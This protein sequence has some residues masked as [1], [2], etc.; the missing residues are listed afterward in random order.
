MKK[1]ITPRGFLPV[2]AALLLS[3]AV[4]FCFSSCEP[5][6]YG[7]IQQEP[8]SQALPRSERLPLV[9]DFVDDAAADYGI[10]VYMP[11]CTRTEY[12]C[13][14][15]ITDNGDGTFALD[16]GKIKFGAM[17]DSLL[18]RVVFERLRIVEHPDQEGLYSLEAEEPG[19][20]E[21]LMTADKIPSSGKRHP[22]YQRACVRSKSAGLNTERSFL[23]IRK[24]R[25]LMKI[26]LDW[27]L[28]LSM[29]TEPGFEDYYA[30]QVPCPDSLDYVVAGVS[31][32]V[33]Y[34]EAEKTE[35]NDGCRDLI[36][37]MPS[38][39][40]I[41]SYLVTKGSFETVPDPA[42]QDYAVVMKPGAPF[43]PGQEERAPQDDRKMAVVLTEEYTVEG[44]KT[45]FIYMGHGAAPNYWNAGVFF[46]GTE[47]TLQP[48][49]IACYETTYR[50]WYEVY[51][52]AVNNGYS[53]YSPGQ[54][55]SFGE[56]G[57]ES[58]EELEGL[59]VSKINWRDALVWCNAYSEMQGLEPV[60]YKDAA[61]GEPHR[62]SDFEIGEF[63]DEEPYRGYIYQ[64][65]NLDPEDPSTKGGVDWPY[66]KPGAGGYRLPTEAEW[67]FACRGGDP[68][69]EDWWY[70]Y[71]GRQIKELEDYLD[72]NIYFGAG[73]SGLD[74]GWI[75]IN[76]DNREHKVG[77]KRPNRLGLYD[78]Y[79]NAMEFC[80]DY[81]YENPY[82]AD[83]TMKDTSVP[84]PLGQGACYATREMVVRK[85][86][87]YRNEYIM[88]QFNF[89]DFYGFRV[90]RSLP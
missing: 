55:G 16:S 53:F 29:S 41:Y 59:P 36:N 74:M 2:T 7:S 32:H 77:N 71:P 60:Y 20:A 86:V 21:F 8:P 30:M 89:W 37:V 61:F 54:E 23:S 45:G 85:N 6:T 15:T 24:N 38:K 79:G 73:D 67:E 17:G 26:Y 87:Y 28:D 51:S 25:L 70:I 90:A 12:L 64:P 27:N 49:E 56:P 10:Y 48:Y 40:N 58:Q 22:F 42:G 19:H 63:N 83:G 5:P 11:T 4:L 47:C 80:F 9:Q 75:G 65:P 43:A 13:P 18:T 62:S 50:L 1:R 72:P 39:D 46:E 78:M 44:D 34:T 35:V 3:A 76:N 81:Y 57:A 33:D 68:D 66:V 82:E 69:R 84:A 31:Y 88:P 14:K 52:W